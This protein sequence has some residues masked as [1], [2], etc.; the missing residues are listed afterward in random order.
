MQG[1]FHCAVSAAMNHRT[2]HEPTE[3]QQFH[4]PAGTTHISAMLNQ[5]HALQNQ[6][7]GTRGA[8]ARSGAIAEPTLS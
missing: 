5:R 2:E 4:T 7:Q 8:E 1:G 3:T 6:S